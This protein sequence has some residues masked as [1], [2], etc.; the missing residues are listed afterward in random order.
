[1]VAYTRVLVRVEG[2][3]RAGL[4]TRVH[5]GGTWLRVAL[6]GAD[7]LPQDYPAAACRP[8]RPGQRA[9]S[10]GEPRNGPDAT[11]STP[12]PEAF[13]WCGDP[14]ARHAVA[15]KRTIPPGGS[16]SGSA[17][18]AGPAELDAPPGQLAMVL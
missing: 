4:V 7:G 9:E 10:H 6:D 14:L 11:R 17:P 13:C 2:E 8:Q 1:M 5:R 16:L 3:R 18:T 12:G 15:C